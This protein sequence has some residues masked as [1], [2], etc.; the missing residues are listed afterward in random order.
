MQPQV[1]DAGFLDFLKKRAPAPSR[2][3]PL[4]KFLNPDIIEEFLTSKTHMNIT[5]VTVEPL[6]FGVKLTVSVFEDRPV[7]RT[8]TLESAIT[9]MV[10]VIEGFLEA[11]VT[12]RVSLDVDNPLFD[13]SEGLAIYQILLKADPP[14]DLSRNA[15]ARRVATKV[16]LLGLVG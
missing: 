1:R 8:R 9:P 12:A 5:G 2:S 10:G 14:K 4:S 16:M 3:N 6:G 15:S 7:N 11:P 13:P